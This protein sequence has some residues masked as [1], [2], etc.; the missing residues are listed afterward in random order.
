MD[1]VRD[2][3]KPIIP[4]VS[5]PYLASVFLWKRIDGNALLAGTSYLRIILVE[6]QI[7][8]HCCSVHL[9]YRFRIN[10]QCFRGELVST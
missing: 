9:L 4:D 8:H 2:P 3:Q 1:L 5:H 10:S 6:T 7:E